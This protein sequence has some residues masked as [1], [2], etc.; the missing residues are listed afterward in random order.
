MYN[1]KETRERKEGE[2]IANNKHITTRTEP[3]ATERDNYYTTGT[4]S[5]PSIGRL[6]TY[7]TCIGDCRKHISKFESILAYS[8]KN[9]TITLKGPGETT[10]ITSFTAGVQKVL[11]QSV[12]DNPVQVNAAYK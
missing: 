12:A 6:I 9:E 2:K 1:I 4:Q 11:W 8:F 10:A 5:H 3:H 7:V